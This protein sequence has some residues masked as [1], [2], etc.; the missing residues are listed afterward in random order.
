MK[1]IVYGTASCKLCTAAKKLLEEKNYEYKYI[2]VGY[3]ISKEQMM[4]KLGFTVQT[5]PQIVKMS[6][7]F[8]EYVG[9]FAEL[10]ESM[11]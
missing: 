4:E 2:E 6:D 7:G 11:K 10:K 8:G 1:Y 5:V 3:E 9:G